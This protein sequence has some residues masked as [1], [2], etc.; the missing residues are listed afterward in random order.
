[1]VGAGPE[2]GTSAGTT[3]WHH[4][5]QVR[6]RSG[7]IVLTRGLGEE[8]STVLETSFDPQLLHR[9]ASAYYLD[10]MRQADIATRLGVSRPT[11]SKLLAEARRIGMV[12]FEVLDPSEADVGALG[13]RVRDALGID[14]VLVAPGDQGQRDYRGLGELLGQALRGL[15]LQRGDVL[16]L[17][18]GRTTH[19]VSGSGAL[20][21]LPGVVVVPTVGGQQEPDPWFQTNETVRR[22][23]SGTQSSPRFVFA[24][25]LP[26]EGLWESLQADPSFLTITSLWAGAR[27]A[28]TGI[29]AP[30]PGREALTSVV[31]RDEPALEAAMGDICLHFFDAAG[32]PVEFPGSDRLV[33][34]PLEDLRRIPDLV[35]LAAGVGKA[36]SIVAGTRAGLI[37]TLITDAPTAEAILALT[38]A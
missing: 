36:P 7:A 19:T 11:V 31:P 20:P 17:S 29:G 27:V 6:I 21:K 8:V 3:G 30:Y 22:F 10:D 25:A 9:A 37:T 13:A 1:M 14:A 24:P 28:V 15:G 16:L 34:P 2:T 32:G 33:R 38:S 12:R 35:A 26:S 5:V 23:T 18:S 4:G